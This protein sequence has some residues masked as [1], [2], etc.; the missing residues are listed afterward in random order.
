MR[1]K[2]C[3]VLVK[4]NE[5]LKPAMRH[6]IDSYVGAE[7]SWM[8]ANFD[9]LS[10]VELLVDKGKDAIKGLPKNIQGNKDA[11]AETFTC[12]VLRHNRVLG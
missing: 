12:P 10:L 9:D 4:S 7:E 2:R 6:L 3:V 8:L 1:F 11:I 5:K